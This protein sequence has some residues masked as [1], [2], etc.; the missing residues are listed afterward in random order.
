MWLFTTKQHN[1]FQL[2]PEK[3]FTTATAEGTMAAET[4]AWICLL[5]PLFSESPMQTRNL[6]ILSGKCEL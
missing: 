3:P 4:T 2:I 1:K 6:D 5:F